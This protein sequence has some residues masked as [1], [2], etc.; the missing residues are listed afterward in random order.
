MNVGDKYNEE[1][2][3]DPVEKIS[4]NVNSNSGILKLPDIKTDVPVE[5]AS[6]KAS[7][8]MKDSEPVDNKY[9]DANLNDPIKKFLWK[10]LN[11]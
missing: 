11:P 1:N 4:N 8:A 7:E 9:N 5:K 2:L 6:L 3:S 10:T